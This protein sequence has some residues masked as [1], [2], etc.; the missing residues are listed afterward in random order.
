MSASE[1]IAEDVFGHSVSGRV[2]TEIATESFIGP[3][4]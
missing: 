1:R 2:Y 3:K 4:I